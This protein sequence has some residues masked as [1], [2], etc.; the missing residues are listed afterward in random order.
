MSRPHSSYPIGQFEF[1]F[2]F[3]VLKEMNTTDTEID[4]TNLESN[5]LYRILVYARGVHGT[6]L[7]SSM[8]L[9]NTT[10]KG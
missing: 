2:F 1:N 7:P 8:L 5:A 3:F 10:E 6:S 4:L 9:I